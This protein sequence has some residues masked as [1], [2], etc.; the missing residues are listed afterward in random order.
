MKNRLLWKV[1]TGSLIFLVCFLMGTPTVDAMKKGHSGGKAPAAAESMKKSMMSGSESGRTM[2]S[3][4]G[5]SG[6]DG[7]GMMK[8][9][10]AHMMGGP[11]G[12]G[13]K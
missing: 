6:D 1:W 3:M 4:M 12:M 8:M 5:D 2:G 11:G 9:M 10:M 7:E 13:K